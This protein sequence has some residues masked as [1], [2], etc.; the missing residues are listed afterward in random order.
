M[1]FSVTVEENITFN[2]TGYG[3]GVGLS[4]TGADSMAKTGS[5]FEQIINHYYTGIKIENI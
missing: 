1:K 2:V 3:H 4:Q 5:N